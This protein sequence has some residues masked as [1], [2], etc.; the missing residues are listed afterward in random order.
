MKVGQNTKITSIG[1]EILK[2]D[3]NSNKVKELRLSKKE[4]VL[5]PPRVWIAFISW[6]GL[7]F[8]IKRYVIKYPYSERNLN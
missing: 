6:Y 2:E 1:N 8:E 5:V 3:I 4:F 7:T